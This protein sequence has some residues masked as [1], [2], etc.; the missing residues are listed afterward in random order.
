MPGPEIEIDTIKVRFHP[1]TNIPDQIYSFDDY[2]AEPTPLNGP[3]FEPRIDTTDKAAPWYPFNTRNDFELAELMVDAHLN[4]AQVK[5][6]LSII[7]KVA[8]DGSS[9]TLVDLKDLH[10]RWE[11]ARNT[12]ANTVSNYSG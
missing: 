7:G 8:E 2:S 6:L 10:A 11:V 12:K 4:N 1:H 3:Q 9:F 5:K